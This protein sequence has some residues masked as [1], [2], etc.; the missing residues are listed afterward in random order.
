MMR[1]HIRCSVLPTLEYHAQTRRLFLGNHLRAMA[2]FT[3]QGY[4]FRLSNFK[5]LAK[6]SR[7]RVVAEVYARK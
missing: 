6:V 3:F 1:S 2:S 7:R 4:I 5:F